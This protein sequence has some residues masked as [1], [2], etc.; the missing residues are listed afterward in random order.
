MADSDAKKDAEYEA[1][2]KEEMV[3]ESKKTAA[4]KPADAA[5]VVPPIPAAPAA[6]AESAKFVVLESKPVLWRGGLTMLRKGKILSE[7]HYG[8]DGI[9]HLVKQGVKLEAVK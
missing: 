8:K 9:E 4:K 2:F 3:K 5:P 7:A 6:P 1:A